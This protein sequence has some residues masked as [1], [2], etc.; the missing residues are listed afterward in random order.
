MSTAL[1]SF[2]LSAV[3]AAAL[4]GCSGSPNSS[5]DANAKP[6]PTTTGQPESD[7]VVNVYNWS[8]YID[9]SVVTDFQKE[10]GI[11]VNYDVFDSNEVLETKLLTGHTNYDVVA[12]SGPF[13]AR[14]IQAGGYQK[15]DKS[16][17]PN[18]KSLDPEVTK[19]VA[20]YDAG[21]TYAVT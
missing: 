13:L 2:C 14:P 15:I 12:P 19:K 3:L 8:D 16:Q 21:N 18:W 5:A 20:Q 1:R 17:L 10:Y 9:P 4:A 6:T 7:K 11:K